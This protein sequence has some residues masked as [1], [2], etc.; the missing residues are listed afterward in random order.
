MPHRDLGRLLSDVDAV[1]RLANPLCPWGGGNVAR[2]FSARLKANRCMPGCWIIC[3]TAATL[4]GPRGLPEEARQVYDRRDSAAVLCRTVARDS[5]NEQHSPMGVTS[6]LAG[7]L[8]RTPD[9]CWRLTSVDT[10][11]VQLTSAKSDGTLRSVPHNE[12]DGLCLRIDCIRMS[13][14]PFTTNLRIHDRKLSDVEDGDLSGD[15]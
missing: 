7:T 2:A 13:R 4:N 5:H 1:G 11:S 14:L 9:C 12:A 8:G 10:T 15:R 6:G 3:R